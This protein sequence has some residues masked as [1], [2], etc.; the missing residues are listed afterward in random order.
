MSAEKRQSFR[1]PTATNGQTAFLRIRGREFP[2]NVLDISA[3]GMSVRATQRI[4]AR[5]GQ[6]AC[7]ESPAGISEVEIV[8][9]R[10]A[11]PGTRI[12]LRRINDL[13]D[14]RALKTHG[15]SGRLAARRTK[16]HQI[17]GALGVAVGVALWAVI[18]L[19]LD[20]LHL[21]WLS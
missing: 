21:P 17:A 16:T 6:N 15:A 2:V 19:W 12:G 5:I 7:L 20:I 1:C 18:C 11:G 4:K 3:G 8:S 10:P 14:A 9:L 13:P